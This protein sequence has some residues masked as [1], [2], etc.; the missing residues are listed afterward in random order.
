MVLFSIQFS[1]CTLSNVNVL[2]I[3]DSNR[4]FSSIFQALLLICTN[5]YLLIQSDILQQFLTPTNFSEEL[6]PMM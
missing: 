2:T 6:E 3:L 1:A 5:K 4:L